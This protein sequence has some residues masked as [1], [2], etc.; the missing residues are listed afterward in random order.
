[1]NAWMAI[2]ILIILAAIIGSVFTPLGPQAQP[3]IEWSILW[4]FFI[5]CPIAL[6][7]VVGIQY[8]NPRSDAHWTRPDWKENPFN[9]GNPVQIFHLGAYVFLAQGSVTLMRILMSPIDVYP[10]AFVTI[11]IGMG[12]LLGLGLVQLAFRKKFEPGT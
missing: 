8:L 12:V 7:L 2:R 10:E 4:I 9:F 6:I 11:L 5:F 3:P 1:M